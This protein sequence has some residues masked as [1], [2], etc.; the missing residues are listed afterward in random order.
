MGYADGFYYGQGRIICDTS[1]FSVGDT[2]RVRSVY[3]VSQTEDKQVVTVGTPL[4]FTVPPYDYYKICKVEEINNVETEIGGEYVTIDYGQTHR[5]NVLDKSTLS[6]CKGIVNAH[7][8]TNL[9]AIGDEVTITVGGNPWIVQVADFDTYE[10]NSIIF[11]SKNLTNPQ[12]WDSATTSDMYYADGSQRN[13][14]LSFYSDVAQK[15]KDCISKIQKV[16]HGSMAT[17]NAYKAFE[18][19]MWSPNYCEVTGITTQATPPQPIYQFALFT[20]QANRI[21]TYNGSGLEWWTCDGLTQNTST[22][23]SYY[24]NQSGGGSTT[25]NYPAYGLCPCFM[26]KADS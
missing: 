1:T 6:G 21:K 12:A 20:T 2:I 14:I 8:H 3:N 24:I 11:V 10:P 25:Y 19:Y 18:D 7:Q 13:S 5:S 15:D 26:I 4:V 9:L 16:G 22:R 17:T 23:A